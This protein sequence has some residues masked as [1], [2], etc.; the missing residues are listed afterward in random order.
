MGAM[1]I[2]LNFWAQVTRNGTMRI[3]RPDRRSSASAGSTASSPPPAAEGRKR[4]EEPEDETFPKISALCPFTSW[5]MS[6]R[7]WQWT[8]RSS[9]SYLT[10]NQG[11]PSNDR[12]NEYCVELWRN[13][14][15]SC[16]TGKGHGF[17]GAEIDRTPALKAI[18]SCMN[19]H[20]NCK[21]LFVVHSAPSTWYNPF[22]TFCIRKR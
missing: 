6:Q 14:G 8:D 20:T 7:N 12:N 10:W 9:S 21:F 17:D 2:A 1:Q 4:L 11:E 15:H 13:S 3:V 19:P 16:A 22:F 5:S 18:A